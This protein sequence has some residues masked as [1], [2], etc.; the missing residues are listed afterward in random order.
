MRKFGWAPACIGGGG[1]G[2]VVGRNRTFRKRP[3]A[4]IQTWPSGQRNG[5]PPKSLRLQ[6]SLLPPRIDPG[7]RKNA[8]EALRCL[9]TAI[10]SRYISEYE[11]EEAQALVAELS[12]RLV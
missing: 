4:V 9:A 11:R 2:G 12:P 7:V 3:I 6:A 5:S 10:G 8:E 1:L